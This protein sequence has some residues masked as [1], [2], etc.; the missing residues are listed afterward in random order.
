MNKLLLC[1]I[2]GVASVLPTHAGDTVRICTYNILK[3]SQSNEDGR[4]PHFARILDSIR[5]HILVTQEVDD[6]SAGPR[7]V[8]EVL[9]WAP[10]ASTPF[11]DGPDTDNQVYYN[12]S[13]FDLVNVRTIATE[14]RN[15]LETTLALRPH[16]GTLA[17]TIVLYS[18]HLKASDGSTEAAQR[19]REMTKLID[20]LAPRNNIVVC[21]DFNVYSPAEASYTALTGSSSVRRFVDPLGTAWRRNVT[22]Q[23][24]IYTQCTRL[25]TLGVCGGGVS[26]GLDD[27]FDFVLFSEQLFT[28]VMPSTYTSFGN[29]GLDRLDQ[30]IDVPPN[31]RVSSE[32]AAALK[33]A[34]DHLPVYV[35][36]VLGTFT[37]NVQDSRTSEFTASV[38]G[39]TLVLRGCKLGEV[40]KV[41]SVFGREILAI[42][43]QNEVEL[44]NIAHLATGAYVVTDGYSTGRFE[45]SR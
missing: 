33:C 17:D 44:I 28:R 8:S 35:D 14:L 43:V 27:R 10:F 6:A 32:L 9:T 7:F 11:I 5:P 24:G 45:I 34:S 29:D 12:Q 4:I 13:M 16:D 18:V 30:S 25:T 39:T 37:A 15:I 2:V 23:A 20:A 42:T 1:L 19:H 38:V 22:A 41:Y 21:G 36:F 31:T 26:G 3:F 40:L